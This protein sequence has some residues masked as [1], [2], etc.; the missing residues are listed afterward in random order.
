MKNNFET[1]AENRIEFIK[2][3]ALDDELAKCILN[4]SANF[5]D[6]TVTDAE[7][8]G[9]MYTQIYPFIKTVGTL[10]ETKAYITMKFSYK[11]VKGANIFKVA[12]VTF[13]AFCHES[14][15]K[16]PYM[17]IRPDYMLQQIDR[18]MNDTRSDGWLGKLAL[19]DMSDIVMD[20][21]GVYIG[22]AITYTDTEF[23]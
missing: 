2:R 5:K 8:Y 17:I 19:Y 10:T 15:I 7:K 12:S 23:Q 22:S 16:T 3:L 11:K 4:K 9:L 6:T 14:I 20:N 21:N 18:L 13:Y 1:L